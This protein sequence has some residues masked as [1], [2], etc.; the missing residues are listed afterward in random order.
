MVIVLQKQECIFHCPR[1]KGKFVQLIMKELVKE[2]A[3]FIGM[4]VLIPVI[5]SCSQK[6]SA[7]ATVGNQKVVS[8]NSDSTSKAPMTPNRSVAIDTLLYPFRFEA[9]EWTT[10][11]L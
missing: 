6:V 8:L 11:S 7:V 10:Y 9:G 1:W 3:G 4:L 2:H 5:L